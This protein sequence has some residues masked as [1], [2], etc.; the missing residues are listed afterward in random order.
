MLKITGVKLE[1]ISDIGMYLFIEK[2][3]RGG[4]YYI[5]KR[6]NKANNKYMKNFYP[7]KLSK[8]IIYFD[9]NNLYGWAMN[10]YLPYGQFKWL[11]KFDKFDVNSISENSSIGY[12]FKVDFEYSDELHY[13]Y[14]D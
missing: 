12:V 14:I 9:A 7:K 11:K 13:L 1:Q 10:R 2:G 6:F 3:L 4:I 8:Y 5:C